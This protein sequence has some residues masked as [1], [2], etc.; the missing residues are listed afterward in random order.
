MIAS[1]GEIARYSKR[2]T[3]LSGGGGP[4]TSGWPARGVNS[5]IGYFS[6]GKCTKLNDANCYAEPCCTHGTVVSADGNT[7]YQWNHLV[8]G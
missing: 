3:T 1:L 8:N 4:S 6:H 5:Y 2:N 7:L